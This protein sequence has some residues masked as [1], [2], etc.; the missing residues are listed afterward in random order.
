MAE[1]LDQIKEIEVARGFWSRFRGWMGRNLRSGTALLIYPCSS[2][3]TFFMREAIDVIFLDSDGRV[4][5]VIERLLPW[6]VS[7]WVREAVAVL[8]LPEGRARKSG[9]KEG[10]LLPTPIAELVRNYFN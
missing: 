2:V 5:Q 4:I 9:V 3:H 1:K 6:R 8:E 10:E 7:P